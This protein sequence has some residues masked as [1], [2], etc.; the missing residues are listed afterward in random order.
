[1]STLRASI[2]KDNPKWN[3]GKIDTKVNFIRAQYLPGINLESTLDICKLY[4]ATE[5]KFSNGVTRPMFFLHFPRVHKSI[6][7]YYPQT[8]ERERLVEKLNKQSVER[9][10]RTLTKDCSSSIL[11]L[12]GAKSMKHKHSESRST[13][14]K[15]GRKS[16]KKSKKHKDSNIFG[17]INFTDGMDV[18][19]LQQSLEKVTETNSN[20]VKTPSKK[21]KD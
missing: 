21:N 20:R 13:M 11:S 3:D 4:L 9:A 16:E 14:S 18:N 1:M 17:S 12:K 15:K 10:T 8:E 6:F 2:K 5:M 7:Q 19:V